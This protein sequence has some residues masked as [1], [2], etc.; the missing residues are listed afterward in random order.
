M[1]INIRQQGESVNIFMIMI[2]L[3]S[4][5]NEMPLMTKVGKTAMAGDQP[6][7]GKALAEIEGN[8]AIFRV[9][10]D[11]GFFPEGYTLVYFLD[12]EEAAEAMKDG[13]IPYL[14]IPRGTFHSG[15]SPITDIWKK[16]FQKPG[17]EH[18]LGM[19]E[20]NSMPEGIYVDMISVRPGWQRNRIATQ[21]INLLKKNFPNAKVTT[22]SQTDKGKKLAKSM[23]IPIA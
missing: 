5:I 12:S 13:K 19:I 23:D 9:P 15:G 6:L 4:L 17:T 22:S 8:L 10:T 21:M 16:R 3:K 20:G 14:M 18:I 11:G 7:K 2:K 1:I